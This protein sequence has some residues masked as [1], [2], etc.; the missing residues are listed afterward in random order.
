MR[1]ARLSPKAVLKGS[2][3]GSLPNQ[4][5]TGQPCENQV[6]SCQDKM[7]Q[8]HGH[9]QDELSAC[10]Q[11]ESCAAGLTGLHNAARG[12]PQVALERTTGEWHSQASVGSCLGRRQRAAVGKSSHR[13]LMPCQ[14]EIFCSR[15]LRL[16]A[17]TICCCVKAHVLPAVRLTARP[18]TSHLPQHPAPGQSQTIPARR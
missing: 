11:V 8:G 13:P 1:S 15:P 16:Q 14:G 2:D 4:N 9:K 6:I 10:Q 18:C 3:K 17:Q 5:S 12:V 7:P